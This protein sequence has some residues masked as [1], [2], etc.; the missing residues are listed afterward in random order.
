MLRI[1]FAFVCCSLL[2]ASSA[3][4]QNA[5]IDPARLEEVA[6]NLT[7]RLPKVTITPDLPY[8]FVKQWQEKIALATKRKVEEE[9]NYRRQLAEARLA[10]AVK[11]I[12]KNRLDLA[13]TLFNSYQDQ[14]TVIKTK[15]ADAG[16]AEEAR[17]IQE[18]RLEETGLDYQAALKKLPPEAQEDASESAGT[19]SAETAPS[20]SSIWQKV[21]GVSKVTS[22][23]EYKL[24]FASPIPLNR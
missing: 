18:T 4:A 17:K 15:L 6:G 3:W 12:E 22:E 2:F 23:D 5:E 9:V 16:I 11:M 8:Y 7:E 14:V 19:T 10:E 21:L 24:P 13:A 1:I 20:E